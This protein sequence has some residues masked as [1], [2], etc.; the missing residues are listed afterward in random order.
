MEHA[1]FEIFSV[2][3]P[4]PLTKALVSFPQFVTKVKLTSVEG[5]LYLSAD[6]TPESSGALSSYP[7]TMFCQLF[8]VA[9]ESPDKAVLVKKADLLK[10]LADHLPAGCNNL[11]L[12]VAP[13]EVEARKG[14]YDLKIMTATTGGVLEAVDSLDCELVPPAVIPNL[15]EYETAPGDPG[16]I[17]APT[18]V[19]VYNS[20]TLRSFGLNL[21]QGKTCSRSIILWCLL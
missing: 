21:R 15:D 7:V 20:D 16:P 14:R 8:A 2:I 18:G 4:E 19:V 5:F 9:G 13:S 1:P 12:D 11:Q 3:Y 10:T 6:V 17:E